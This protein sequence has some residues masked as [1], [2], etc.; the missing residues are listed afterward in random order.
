MLGDK[1][2]QKVNMKGYRNS[3]LKPAYLGSAFLYG[4]V[5]VTSMGL[6]VF[7]FANH[8]LRFH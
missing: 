8:D 7:F 4:Y 2:K 5:D 3:P 6:V 1:A